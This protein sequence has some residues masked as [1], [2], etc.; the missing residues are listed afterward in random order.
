[1][2]AGRTGHAA[3]HETIKLVLTTPKERTVLSE[4]AKDLSAQ[5][6]IALFGILAF[7]LRVGRVNPSDTRFRLC[8]NT[9]TQKVLLGSFQ[10]LVAPTITPLL[11][12]GDSISTFR[13]Y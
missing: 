9:A 6:S 1:M 12:G 3:S 10:P 11:L 7:G 2:Y 13:R 5:T 4:R 8:I